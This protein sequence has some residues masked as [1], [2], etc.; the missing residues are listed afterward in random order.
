MARQ[1]AHRIARAV[2]GRSHRSAG[3]D[4]RRANAE[5]PIR[6]GFLS[7][8]FCNHLV[9]HLMCGLYRR[10]DRSRFTVYAFDY[11]TD[12]G[13]LLVVCS[14]YSLRMRPPHPSILFSR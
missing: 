11:S 1:Q 14:I 7:H 5:G 13:S 2:D 10:F 9:S 6:V 8:E 4:R 12:D 3:A